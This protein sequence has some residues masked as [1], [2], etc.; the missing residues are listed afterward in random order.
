M[1]E[2]VRV[3]WAHSE[4]DQSMAQNIQHGNQGKRKSDLEYLVR[5]EESSQRL[6]LVTGNLLRGLLVFKQPR[7]HHYK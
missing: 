6:Q 2:R 3:D 5:I 1:N 4:C 7:L